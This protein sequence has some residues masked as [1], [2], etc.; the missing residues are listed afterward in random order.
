MR[1]IIIEKQTEFKI[2]IVAE[3]IDVLT[4]NSPLYY[5]TCGNITSILDK[6]LDMWAN[7][8][9]NYKLNLKLIDSFS[10]KYNFLYLIDEIDSKDKNL[11]LS[12]DDK[13]LSDEFL[14]VELKMR[15]GKNHILHTSNNGMYIDYEY[16]AIQKRFNCTDLNTV[17]NSTRFDSGYIR[18]QLNSLIDSDGPFFLCRFLN[19]DT[20]CRERNFN[21]HTDFVQF[22]SFLPCNIYTKS[23][24]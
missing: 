20:V 17:F 21:F 22:I 11:A 14:N 24:N 16:S 4:Y 3:I 9:G 8:N 10:I 19:A 15:N 2:P 7:K 23:F 12:N 18:S 13:L 1:K 5:N 6:V